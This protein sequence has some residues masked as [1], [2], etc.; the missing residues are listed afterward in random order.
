MAQLHVIMVRFKYH[1][2]HLADSDTEIYCYRLVKPL[3]QYPNHE[4]SFCYIEQHISL[5]FTLCETGLSPKNCNEWKHRYLLLVRVAET[6]VS[7]YGV[8]DSIVNL[9]GYITLK[10]HSYTPLYSTFKFFENS[11]NHPKS[12]NGDGIKVINISNSP[13]FL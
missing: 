9:V 4:L 11:L 7:G 5:T 10:Y 6:R 13:S 1:R 12:K 2:D 3:I 8:S